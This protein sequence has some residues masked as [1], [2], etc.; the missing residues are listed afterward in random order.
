MAIENKFH[1]PLVML[2]ELS[3]YRFCYSFDPLHNGHSQPTFGAEGCFLER[4]ITRVE[5]SGLLNLSGLL[6]W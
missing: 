1:F 4:H 5:L 2:G 3:V 6:K